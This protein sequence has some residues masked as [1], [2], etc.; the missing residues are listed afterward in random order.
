M[1]IGLMG[2]TFDPP[3][4][5][6]V[7]PV[8]DAAA[9]F[10][11]DRVFYV[12]AY[13]PPHK[14]R[15]NL[16]DPFH[17]CAMVAIALQNDPHFLLSPFEL[18]Q[19]GVSFTIETVKHFKSLLAATDDLFFLMGSDS[20]L[21]FHTWKDYEKLIHLCR[22]IIISRGIKDRELKANLQQL[23]T[24][25]QLDLSEIF[26]FAAARELPI[27]S[28]EIR[29]AISAGKSVSATLSPEVEAYIVKH[30]L[31]QRR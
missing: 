21:E 19:A 27:S 7:L 30:S 1:K 3:H 15:P 2:G 8:Q 10:S 17:R 20:F 12:P 29:S 25:L 24:H 16:T 6:H 28:T 9:Q 22:F 13:I 14:S 5:G 31:Y 4:L 11:L 18:L 26:L 23:E